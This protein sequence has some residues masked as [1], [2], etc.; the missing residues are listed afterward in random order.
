M[1]YVIQ[2]AYEDFK[3]VVLD[4][5]FTREDKVQA[6]TQITDELLSVLEDLKG[7]EEE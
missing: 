3:D 7:G 4:D 6:L 1:R 2:V 5:Q